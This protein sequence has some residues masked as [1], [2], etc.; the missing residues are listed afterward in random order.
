MRFRSLWDECTAVGELYPEHVFGG[1]ED[2]KQKLQDAYL[3]RVWRESLGFLGT[4]CIRRII[5]ECRGGVGLPTCMQRQ[6]Y[7]FLC[8]TCL[9]RAKMRQPRALALR[10]GTKRKVHAVRWTL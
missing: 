6:L 3:E 9:G 1:H 5:G 4:S 8:R 10:R 7:L 2:N